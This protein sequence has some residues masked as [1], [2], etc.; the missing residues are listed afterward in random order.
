M[1]RTVAGLSG[2]ARH[3]SP[4]RAGGVTAVASLAHAPSL[5]RAASLILMS[6]VAL[7]GC[8]G[9]TASVAPGQD[10]VSTR[11]GNLLAFNSTSA[12]AA[13][14]TNAAVLRIDCPIIQVEPGAASFRSGGEA[15]GSVRYQIALGDVA[16]DCT[17]QGDR[18]AVRVG[19]ETNVVLGP[20]GS[21]GSYT[22]PLRITI[23]R[24]SDEAVLASKIYRVGGAATFAGPATY[25]LVADALTVP[26]INERAADDYEVVVGFGE[27]PP[28]G[29]SPRARR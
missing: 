19:V 14:G 24:Q 2:T 12:P 3:A 4:G 22:A 17:Q 23:R 8:N 13:P 15:S 1:Q 20:A 11:L 16:R 28:A 6:S 21:P 10:G 9:P 7:A 29:R 26:F 27:G 5:A 18:L 25:T